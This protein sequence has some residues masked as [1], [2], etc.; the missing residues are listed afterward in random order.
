MRGTARYA[1]SRQAPEMSSDPSFARRVKRLVVVSASA[2]GVILLL[3]ITA[4]AGGRLA[5]GLILGGWITMPALLARS[6]STPKWRYLL[7]VP[8][9]LVATG[10][11][12]VTVEFDGS[13]LGYIGWLMMTAGVLVGATLGAWFWYR[14]AP[15][16][17]PLDSPF[18]QGRWALIAI[19]AALV[20]VG[21]V[22]VIVGE[23]V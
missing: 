13:A 12:I 1:T 6:L 4:G 9:G 14:W 21:A 16:P 20:T 2:L 22:L 8:A 17:G 3:T 7:V 18:S 19:H 11:V 5:A 23:L 15:V 10:L